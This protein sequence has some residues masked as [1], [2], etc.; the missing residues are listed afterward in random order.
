M[1]SEKQGHSVVLDRRT[2]DHE[3]P[4]GHEKAAHED[5]VDG[6]AYTQG[7]VLPPTTSL[8]ETSATKRWLHDEL[9]P[10]DAEVADRSEEGDLL[11]AG[12]PMTKLPKRGALGD[13]RGVVRL[14]FAVLTPHDA[15]R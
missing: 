9:R 6:I 3:D 1:P 11:L 7:G 14:R 13:D 10:R 2:V 15:S 8:D 4:L 12:L 5:L